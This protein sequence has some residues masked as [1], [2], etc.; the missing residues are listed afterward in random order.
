[1]LDAGFVAVLHVPF[2]EF[3]N[4]SKLKKQLLH[5]KQ[6]DVGLLIGKKC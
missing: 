2:Y 6:Q 3:G 1:M 4:L 5:I